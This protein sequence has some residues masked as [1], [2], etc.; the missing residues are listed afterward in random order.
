MCAAAVLMQGRRDAG[1]MAEQEMQGTS[2][3]S[4]QLMRVPKQVSSR[5]N[6]PLAVSVMGISC[7]PIGEPAS[8]KSGWY[9]PSMHSVWH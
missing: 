2:P 3:C 5:G 1:H 8:Q 7:P 6:P 9:Q 4:G